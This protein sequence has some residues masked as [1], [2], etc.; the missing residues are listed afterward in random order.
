MTLFIPDIHTYKLNETFFADVAIITTT[1]ED[2]ILWANRAAERL[3]GCKLP[4][5]K[6]RSFLTFFHS[7]LLVK[8]L[9]RNVAESS[10]FYVDSGIVSKCGENVDCELA[11]WV[12][13]GDRGLDTVHIVI[14]P[15]QCLRDDLQAAA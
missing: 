15:L 13:P 8:D 12:A 10:T 6:N 5:L 11:A 1:L 7:D 14:R 2:R 3:L 4:D 9:G